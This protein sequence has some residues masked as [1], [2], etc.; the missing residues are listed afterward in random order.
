[1]SRFDSIDSKLADFAKRLNAQLSDG[2]EVRRDAK[3]Y[4]ERKIRWTEGEIVRMI[5]IS[6]FPF[7]ETSDKDGATWNFI[8]VAWLSN[9]PTSPVPMWEKYLVYKAHLELIATHI[10][11]LLRKSEDN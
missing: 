5:M 1:M 9:S 2:R 8:N 6:Q 11:D 3:G 4:E 10:D 7:D